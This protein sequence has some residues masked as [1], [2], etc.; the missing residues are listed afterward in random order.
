MAALHN[1]IDVT[2]RAIDNRYDF[3]GTSAKVEL[4]EK[5]HLI[6]LY[7][8]SDF[9]LGQIKDLLSSRGGWATLRA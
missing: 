6:T 9:Q 7:G 1:A 2:R 8:D 3:K 4:N 5:D